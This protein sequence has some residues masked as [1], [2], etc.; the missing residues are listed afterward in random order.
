MFID[1]AVYVKVVGVGTDSIIKFPF[2]IDKNVS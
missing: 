1:L 2:A